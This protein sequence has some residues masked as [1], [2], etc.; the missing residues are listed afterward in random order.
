MWFW[1]FMLIS[2]LALP[3]IMMIAGWMMWKH[4]PK[5]INGIYGYRTK[6]SRMNQET[7]KFAHKYCGRLWWKTGLIMLVPTILIFIPLIHSS[8]ET[9]GMIG[10]IP[11][12]LQCAVMIVSIIL[13]ELALKRT[14]TDEGIRK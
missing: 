14:F 5:K 1:W 10:L 12:I 7:W 8:D 9:I 13:T 4:C 2:D 11:C 6:R 3:L